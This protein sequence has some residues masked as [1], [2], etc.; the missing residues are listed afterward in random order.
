MSDS[1]L[2]SPATDVVFRE[3]WVERIIASSASI[4]E[5]AYSMTGS[6]EDV[7]DHLIPHGHPPGCAFVGVSD[8][9]LFMI[10]LHEVK[11]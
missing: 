5:P 8:C 10:G 4:F 3:Q 7:E 6:V 11:T 2:G 9:N 1:N